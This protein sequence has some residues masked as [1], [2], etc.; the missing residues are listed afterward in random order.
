MK[1]KRFAL[2]KQPVLSEQIHEVEPKVST[3][4]K[5]FTIT[6]FFAI[7]LAVKVSE[8]VT[9]ARRPELIG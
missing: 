3:A 6:L 5:F 1:K 8:T 9:V 7:F 4:S 2:E